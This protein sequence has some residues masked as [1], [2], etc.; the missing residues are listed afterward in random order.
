MKA[1]FR[2]IKASRDTKKSGNDALFKKLARA[3]PAG[4]ARKVTRLF[5]NQTAIFT[6]LFRKWELSRL[7]AH[8]TVGCSDD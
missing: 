1:F 5:G 3:I 2:T 6:I 4:P 7:V 8:A